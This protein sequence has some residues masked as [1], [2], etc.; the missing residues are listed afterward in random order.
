MARGKRVARRPWFQPQCSLALKA[1]HNASAPRYARSNNLP[2][3]ETFISHFQCS[4]LSL[5]DS[6]R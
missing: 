5:L 4:D 2:Y 3:Y 6:P 1:R